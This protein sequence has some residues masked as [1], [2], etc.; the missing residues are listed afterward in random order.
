MSRTLQKTTG[1]CNCPSGFNGTRCESFWPH[2][3]DIT[4]CFN[5]GNCTF[6]ATGRL[7]TCPVGFTGPV[8]ETRVNLCQAQQ[9]CLNGETSA[10]DD[11]YLMFVEQVLRLTSDKLI[12][13]FVTCIECKRLTNTDSILPVLCSSY[14]K[15][16]AELQVRKK[17]FTY[18]HFHTCSYCR[19]ANKS[20]LHCTSIIVSRF[21]KNIFHQLR[22]SVFPAK[23][24]PARCLVC[25][26]GGTC[27]TTADPPGF[28]CQCESQFSGPTC[29]SAATQ[30]S[31]ITVAN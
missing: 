18:W 5:G 30:D 9:P 2:G 21:F 12:F 22:K 20:D 23:C 13:W 1:S 15:Y 26:P 29:D 24:K 27:Y 17:S 11:K 19:A 14:R 7:C 10:N 8:C 31:P 28:R 6:A 4:G 3:C 25:S 16:S